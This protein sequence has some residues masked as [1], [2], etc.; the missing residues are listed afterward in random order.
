MKVALFDVSDVSRPVEKYNIT[1]GGRGTDSELLRDH[2]A[3]LFN[4]ERD[5]LAFPVMVMEDRQGKG[6][7]D[8]FHETEFVFQGAYVYHFNL[9]D[10]FELKGKI[11]HL[12]DEDFARYEQYRYGGE[13][14]V[15]RIIFIGE[16]LYTVSGSEIRASD[17][18]TLKKINNL[19]IEQERR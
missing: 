9:E 1:I 4:K 7:R 8:D 17:L 15:E 10:G 6:T 19:L 3:L 11:S 2:K 12:S 14:D 16:A 18:D 13:K 5:L